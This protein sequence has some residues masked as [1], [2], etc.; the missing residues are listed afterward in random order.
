MLQIF[1]F[2]SEASDNEVLHHECIS[3][4]RRPLNH[5]MMRGK[6]EILFTEIHFQL[7]PRILP[8]PHNTNKDKSPTLR[9]PHSIHTNVTVEK[10]ISSY[11]W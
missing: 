2:L 4:L 1:C 3:I 10:P 5:Q 11:I 7:H 6:L 9:L 8:L